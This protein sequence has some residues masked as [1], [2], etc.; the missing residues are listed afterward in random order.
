MQQIQTGQSNNSTVHSGDNFA[1][2][3]AFVREKQ[4]RKEFIKI[5]HGTLWA[6]VAKQTFPTPTKLSSGVTAW[7]R[8]DL[9]DWANGTWKAEA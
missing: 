8:S 5:G 9:I 1:N 4:L 7:K 6:W 3:P 2:L